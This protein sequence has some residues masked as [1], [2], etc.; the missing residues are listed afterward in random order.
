MRI[1]SAGFVEQAR[2]ALGNKTL[3]SAL[4]RLAT[5]FPERRRL[6]Y[7]Q[8]PE[9]P[10]LR[11]IGAEIKD[12]TLAHLDFYLERFEREVVRAGGAVHWARDA[13]EAREIVS[14]L[15][16]SVNARRITKS[17]SM[18]TEEIE[19]NPHLEA[20]GFEVVETDL[21]EYIIQLRQ[22]PPSHILA[23]AIH[24]S[25]EDVADTFVEHHSKY[26][27]NQRQTER[28]ALVNEA[29]QVL[30]DRFL[31]ADVGITGA[32]FLIAENGAVI[33]VTNEGN[34]DLTASLPE[35]HIAV[36]GIEKV[37]PT[38]DDAATLLR[39]LARS[40]T[41]QEFSTYTSL[42]TGARRPGDSSGPRQFH[43]VLLDNGRSDMLGT[44]FQEMLRCI[45]CSACINHCPVYHAVGGH[46]YG[47]N[48][49]GPMGAV[50]TPALAGLEDTAHL[51]NASSFCGRCEE[52][53]PV[54][55]PLPKLMRH[56]REREFERH[57]NPRVARYGLG[58]WRWM[59]RSPWRYRWLTRIA[60]RVLRAL[61]SVP[62]AGGGRWITR[63]PWL[64]GA[65]TGHRD[66]RAPERDTFQA[67]WRSRA[68][69]RS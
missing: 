52:V 55:I 20:Q 33:I 49:S 8:L 9:F 22:E 62:N 35:M 12:H 29:R 7:E 25:K 51:P 28:R 65:W 42:H 4:R 2:T 14:E 54:A 23:P 3:E 66:L 10:E 68:R 44:R 64:A 67:Q 19:L 41:G 46:A 18:V 13:D 24:L 56:W 15:C 58:F 6:A 30:R 5:T 48:Y 53:C 21:G 26:G 1:T 59:A 31:A 32:N 47:S 11:R 37:L 16:H 34:A 50:L 61:S 40:A 17:K 57:M 43:V 39:M 27:L 60:V 63:L 38:L 69:D 36:S 45:R